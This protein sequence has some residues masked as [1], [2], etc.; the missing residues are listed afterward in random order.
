MTSSTSK[1]KTIRVV[2][3]QKID[4][5]EDPIVVSFPGGYPVKEEKEE[6][7]SEKKTNS[8]TA[9]KHRSSLRFTQKR[10]R[11]NSTNGRIVFGHDDTCHYHG[12]A[13][14]RAYDG[15]RTKLCV[16][17]Y[18]PKTKTLTVTLAAEK[19]TVFTLQQSLPRYVTKTSFNKKV[20]GQEEEKEE[21]GHIKRKKSLA[22]PM[23]RYQALY[24][25]FGSNKKQKVL[26][27]QEANRVSVDSVVGAG[28]LMKNAFHSQT[29]MSDSN[30]KAL[31]ENHQGQKVRTKQK[32]TF[33]LLFTFPIILLHF[34]K[35]SH[36]FLSYVAGRCS[37]CLC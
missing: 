14:G 25:D 37:I 4:P 22:T 19:G 15:R 26:R 7:R 10:I 5:N 16:G 21:E 36:I 18:H 11:A 12:L 23:E 32:R 3:P 2:V 30:R 9:S 29:K 8:L 6:D 34:L 17:V 20:L 1:K 31:N 27:S 24:R 35:L 28:T 33:H 13:A